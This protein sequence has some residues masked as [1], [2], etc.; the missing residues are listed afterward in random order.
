M[1]W[2]FAAAA[3]AGTSHVRDGLPLQDAYACRVVDDPETTLIAVVS[4]GA[5]SASHGASGSAFITAEVLHCLSETVTE[6]QDDPAAWLRRNIVRAR[7][8]LL[9]EAERHELPPRQ[10]AATLLC[11]VVAPRWSAFAQIGDGA[12]VTSEP[13]SGQWSW[14]FWPQRGEYANSTSFITD[15]NALDLL[16]VDTV[17]TALEELAMFTDGLQHLVLHYADQ[18]V[19]SPFFETMIRPVRESSAHGEDS[20]LSRGLQSYLQSPTV[21]ARADDDLTLLLATRLVEASCGATS[22]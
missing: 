6:A 16:Q 9:A 18:S 11:A 2:R 20:S 8:G 15:Q 14:L 10:F 22:D 19:H 3:T 1:T 5:G 4:D 12:I 21:S 17:T 13:D 7:E